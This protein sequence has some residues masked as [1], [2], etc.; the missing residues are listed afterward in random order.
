[1]L[2]DVDEHPLPAEGPARGVPHD[3]GLVPGP[4]EATVPA[5]LPVLQVPRLAGPVGALV[6]D[7]DPRDVV[8]V[9]EVLPGSRIAR[10]LGGRVAAAGT[11]DR[12]HAR[13]ATEG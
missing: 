3:R 11:T 9:E 12:R 6:L 5:A 1:V 13:P 7:R 4:H 10:A 8:R 2:A